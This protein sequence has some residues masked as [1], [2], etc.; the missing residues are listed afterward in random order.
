MREDM[1]LVDELRTNVGAVS[2]SL[3]LC[4]YLYFISHSRLKLSEKWQDSMLEYQSML[5]EAISVYK[6]SVSHLEQLAGLRERE[7]V[8]VSERE[9]DMVD[10]R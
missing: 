8:C 2:L 6:D 1:L 9:R 7:C 5:F 10:T 4:V 3:S